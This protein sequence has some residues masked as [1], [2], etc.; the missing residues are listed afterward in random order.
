MEE[1][2]WL[3][4]MGRAIANRGVTVKDKGLNLIGWT[5]LKWLVGILD[6]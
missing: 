3:L 4:K 2:Q 1:K 6:W 5:E